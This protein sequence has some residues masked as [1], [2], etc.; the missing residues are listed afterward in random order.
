[1]QY[2]CVGSAL[3]FNGGDVKAAWISRDGEKMRYWGG[4]TSRRDYYC[5]CGETGALLV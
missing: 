4:A 3:F 1:L 5:A 2:R